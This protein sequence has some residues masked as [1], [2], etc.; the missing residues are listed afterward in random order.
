MNI[1]LG[2]HVSLKN[3]ENMESLD[4][5]MRKHFLKYVADFEQLTTL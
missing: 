1:V 5:T 3:G 2:S 4:K